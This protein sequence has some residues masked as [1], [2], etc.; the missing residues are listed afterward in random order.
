MKKLKNI[1]SCYLCSEI[2]EHRFVS[3][4]VK[5]YLKNNS[6]HELSDKEKVYL[7]KISDGKLLRD[8]WLE[9]CGHLSLF[10]I[11]NQEYDCEGGMGKKIHHAILIQY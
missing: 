2:L 4:H 9:C 3:R 5:E 10:T 11:E 6:A 7:F 1:G 8:L